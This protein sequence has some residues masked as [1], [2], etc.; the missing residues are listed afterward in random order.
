MSPTYAQVIISKLTFNS[1][2]ILYGT[3]VSLFTSDSNAIDAFV[4]AVKQTY[5]YQPSPEV[6][7]NNVED[8]TASTRRQ[9]KSTNTSSIGIILYYTTTLV[10]NS[11]T[12]IKVT[13][14][15]YLNDTAADAQSTYEALVSSIEQSL[16][17]GAFNRT[18]TL[19]SITY[20]SFAVRGKYSSFRRMVHLSDISTI[21][22]LTP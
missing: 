3:S 1:T 8:L 15:E 18:L 21:A 13:V 19:S 5:D 17:S 2:Q 7:I 9:L 12:I 16:A 14:E 22:F 20:K 4:D 6:T 11:T 10:E